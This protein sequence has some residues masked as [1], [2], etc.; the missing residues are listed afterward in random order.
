MKAAG[1]LVEVSIPDSV[2]SI[3]KEAFVW[4]TSLKNID[5]PAGLQNI[6]YA[7][8]RYCWALASVRVPEGTE[9]IDSYAFADC[10]VLASAHL[11]A[12]LKSMGHELFVQ[13]DRLTDLYYA[14]SEEDWNNIEVS[15]LYADPEGVVI[16]YNARNV[17]DAA[18]TDN[19]DG[20]ITV[21]VTLPPINIPDAAN[22]IVL[23]LQGDTL[24]TTACKAVSAGTDFT[25]PAA[26][27]QNKVKLFVWDSLKTMCLADGRQGAC[28]TIGP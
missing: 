9:H 26:W 3:K 21:S 6:G 19:G 25:I 5:L 11:P 20:T 10:S 24:Q 15:I 16:H 7:A 27:R 17:P 1:A 2:T 4:C 8:F 22:I 12:S 18:Y 13:S 14:G 28:N 23:G